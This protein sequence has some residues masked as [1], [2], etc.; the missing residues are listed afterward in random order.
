MHSPA[1]PKYVIK[2]S[3]FTKAVPCQTVQKKTL[4]SSSFLKL[5]AQTSTRKFVLE[6]NIEAVTLTPE[7]N[8]EEMIERLN[9]ARKSAL[10]LIQKTLFEYANSFKTEKTVTIVA[11]QEEEPEENEYQHNEKFTQKSPKP[12]KSPVRSPRQKMTIE[13]TKSPEL[14]KTARSPKPIKPLNS[15]K[16]PRKTPKYNEEEEERVIYTPK[17]SSTQTPVTPQV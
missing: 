7:Y 10:D 8:D 15:A 11:N 6:N 2:T 4:D 13:S 3:V 9:K 16:S 17:R 14:A 5:N 1:P 12:A